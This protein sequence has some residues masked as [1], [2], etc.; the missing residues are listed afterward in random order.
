[1]CS[2]VLL[3]SLQCSLSDRD[4]F[5]AFIMPASK[6]RQ[7]A[8]RIGFTKTIGG[9]IGLTLYGARVK[10]V[11]DG[12]LISDF[13]KLRMQNKVAL[14]DK[15]IRLNGEP[16]IIDETFAEKLKQLTM[17]TIT[18]ERDQVPCH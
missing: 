4:L 13:N 17:L 16:A 7:L 14:G 18:F 1:M 9:S 3:F 11:I 8:Y 15:I 5:I 2:T 10:A 12:G 6:P